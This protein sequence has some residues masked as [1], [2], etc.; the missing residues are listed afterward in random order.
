MA[1]LTCAL[2]CTGEKEKTKS[3]R[4][5]N[6]DFSKGMSEISSFDDLYFLATQD[7]F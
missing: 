1:F 5:D 3:L 7:K 6:L 4:E 2:D